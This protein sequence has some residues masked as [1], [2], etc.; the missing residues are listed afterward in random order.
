M[1]QRSLVSIKQ[2]REK[3]KFRQVWLLLPILAVCVAGAFA[4]EP[5]V[6]SVYAVRDAKIYTVSGPVIAR[7]TIVIRNGLIDAVGANVQVP[8]EATIVDGNGLTVYPGLIDSFTDTG[9]PV[10]ATPAVPAGQRGATPQQR[11]PQNTHEAIFQ[12]PL[13]LT[14]DR[15]LAEQVRPA[16]KNVEAYRSIGI[17][18]ALVVSRDGLLTGQSVL[19]NTGSE[20]IVVK[21]PIALHIN[22]A[23]VRAGYPSTLMGALAVLRQSFSNADWYRTVW[24]RFNT[25]PRGIE[26]PSYDPTL[27]AMVPVVQG[28]LPSVIHADWLAQLKRAVNLTDELKLK[29]I[30]A[31]GMEAGKIAPVLKNKDIAVLASVNYATEKP[32]PGF[33]GNT[34][35]VEW[36]DKEMKELLSNA[37]TLQRAGVRFALQSGFADRPQAFIENI[38]KTMENGLTLDQALRATT[39]SAAEILGIG[40]ALGS[41]EA[42]KIANVVVASGEPFAQGSR[43]RDVFIDGK[44]YESTPE[45]ITNNGGGGQRG[46]ATAA[47]SV[48]SAKRPMVKP[49]SYITPTANEVLIKNATVLTV[50][51]GTIKNGSVLIRGGKIA[52]VGTNVTSSPNAMV[53][54]A[55]GKFLLPGII[56]CHSHMAIE[57]GGNEGTSPV[58][59]NVR[60]SDVIRDDDI[61]IYRALAG[62]T[63]IANVLHGSANVIGGTNAVIKLKWG[64]PA[65]EFMFGAPLG[66]KFA[67]GE[68]P[69]RSN[70]NQAQDSRRWPATRMGVEETLRES[71]TEARRYMKE[72]DDYQAAKQRGENAVPPRKDL[73]LET[74]ADI[75]RGKIMVH[76]HSYVAPEIVMMLNIA[77]EFGFKVRTLQHVLE[78]YKVASE[79]KQHGAMASTFADF[80]GYKVEA[81][82][83]IPYNA[84][85][86]HKF[87]V[88]VSINSDDDERVTRLYEEAGR[89]F[90]YNNGELTEDD[91]L[92]MITL[93][94]AIQLGI[95]N[96][97]GSI[98]V[99]KDADLALFS[100]HPLS[101]YTVVEKTFID[102]QI[103]FD[104]ELDLKAQPREGTQNE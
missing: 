60:I 76:V 2:L 93:N 49:G 3:K 75:L 90:H 31:G 8:P 82:D 34:D 41:L 50:S 4:A 46:A 13:G 103:Y 20:N 65:E 19:I 48:A 16:G 87:G 26:R 59:P 24:E 25:N 96:R 35:A 28:K 95:D 10:A 62:G 23:P 11:A 91:A 47:A 57:G 36:D 21:A 74:L 5:A 68:N 64:R 15:V 70:T 100:A 104:R 33:G 69:K 7:G 6:R 71:F 54:D 99:G 38:R 66:I 45:P 9:L 37:A 78:G 27:E 43:I 86:M 17:T 39:L 30:I 63:T 77:D 84:A 85:I 80:W 101:T 55:T 40:N 88:N 51:K 94:P 29:P 67:L 73:K 61:T 92:K 32:K 72:W 52:A 12:T 22:P 1:H 81:W 14:P 56:D 102:G 83:A 42:G 89:V 58:T 18:S 53:I 97:V 79:I 98:E 44:L